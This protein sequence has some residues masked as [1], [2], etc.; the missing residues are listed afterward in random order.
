MRETLDLA[1]LEYAA[2]TKV[3]NRRELVA[4]AALQKAKSTLNTIST[5]GHRTDYDWNAD[6][7]QLTLLEGHT[8]KAIDYALK[9]ME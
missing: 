6:P 3:R 4:K 8:F 2:I 5:K 1:Y 9:L 7:E